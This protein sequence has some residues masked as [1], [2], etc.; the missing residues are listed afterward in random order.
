MIRRA[1]VNLALLAALG[2]P[3]GAWA[4]DSTDQQ[5]G[6]ALEKD[7]RA[8]M[9]QRQ[10]DLACA[11]LDESA[12]LLRTA[13]AAYNLGEC[14][15]HTE[16]LRAASALLSFSKAE[17]LASKAGDG[18]LAAKARNRIKDLESK[19]ARIALK[20]SDHH[21]AGLAIRIDGGDP[22]PESV[23]Q[24][25]LPVDPGQH[26]IEATAPGKQPWHTKL[27][28]P[29]SAATTTILVEDL[30][31][32]TPR[33][34]PNVVAG[35]P[36]PAR[37]LPAIETPRESR[38][39]GQRTLGLVVGG[40]GIVGVVVGSVFGAMAISKNSDSKA[41]CDPA[42]PNVCDAGKGGKELRD[43][44]LH[45]AMGSTVAF[46]LGLAAVAGGVVLYATAPSNKPGASSRSQQRRRG[47]P[48]EARA[49]LGGLSLAGSF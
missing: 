25:P 6:L 5:A 22:L 7:A 20:V 10:F 41:L 17:A 14:Y 19:L 37:P 26:A 11:K 2:V 39:Q 29:P 27:V 34:S 49:T 33:T 30:T 36:S 32:E 21:A 43:S 35:Q 45:A 15:T 12:R 46:A 47:S 4:Q 28:I 1:V 44:A 18:D 24:T 16:P 42:N 48:L 3:R 9:E 31:D 13:G 23:W 38:G 40:A 8:L